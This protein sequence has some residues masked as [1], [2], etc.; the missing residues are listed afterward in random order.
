MAQY[1]RCQSLDALQA[2][3]ELS[4]WPGRQAPVPTLRAFPHFARL[5]PATC[6]HSD[7]TACFAATVRP[8]MPS[9]ASWG[10]D[11]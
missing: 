8:R 7:R 10:G 9:D 4:S 5:G 2:G 6:G 3:Q 11:G 1:A